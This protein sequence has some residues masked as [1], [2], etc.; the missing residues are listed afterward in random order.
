M[1]IIYKKTELG[2]LKEEEIKEVISVNTFTLKNL[3][4][5]KN[6]LEKELVKIEALILEATKLG[7]NK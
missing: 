4:H 3:L 7:I 5:Q 2:E 1:A 6:S